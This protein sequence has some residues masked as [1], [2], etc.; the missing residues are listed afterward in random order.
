MFELV[1]AVS[2]GMVVASHHLVVYQLQLFPALLAYNHFL[3]VLFCDDCWWKIASHVTDSLCN[4]STWI[5][6][7][8]GPMILFYCLL[9]L[10]V[11]RGLGKA[12]YVLLG[13]I[14][15]LLVLNIQSFV[16]F[17]CTLYLRKFARFWVLL[18]IFNICFNLCGFFWFLYNF[19]TILNRLYFFSCIL[20]FE[21]IFLS[22]NLETWTWL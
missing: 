6:L 13:E 18:L 4:G 3:V 16:L 11:Y 2:L 19:R 10:L 20:Y 15:R 8:L 1:V 14:R 12:F 5:S 9:T 17:E 22:S 21:N 7:V